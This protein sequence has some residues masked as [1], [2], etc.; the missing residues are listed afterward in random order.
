M[1]KQDYTGEQGP[2]WWDVYALI[3]EMER[4]FAGKV[5]ISINREQRRKEGK[6][7]YVRTRFRTYQSDASDHDTVA[8]GTWWTKDEYKTITALIYHQLHHCYNWLYAAKEAAERQ[9][10]F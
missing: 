5:T 9:A 3:D 7:T 10:R 8:K 6:G 1:S 2:G 4:D